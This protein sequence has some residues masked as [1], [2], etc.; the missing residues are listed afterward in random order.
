MRIAFAVLPAL[1]VLLSACG[2]KHRTSLLPSSGGR[3][4]EV[5]LVVDTE[6]IVIAEL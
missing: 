5:L 1:C 2:L 3:P 6:R 4:Y